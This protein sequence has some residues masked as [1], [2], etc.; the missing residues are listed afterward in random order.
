MLF[1][2]SISGKDMK[3]RKAGTKRIPFSDVAVFTEC[4]DCRKK[5]TIAVHLTLI[6]S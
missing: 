2:R 1:A 6:M 5:K 4:M 3:H